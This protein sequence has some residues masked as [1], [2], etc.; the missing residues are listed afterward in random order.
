MA[1][2][3]VIIDDQHDG[4]AVS[5]TTNREEDTYLFDA[6]KREE[7]LKIVIH[8]I[9]KTALIVIFTVLVT[10]FLIRIGHFIIPENLRWLSETQLQT[11]DK[12][13]FSGALGGIMT[14]HI[15]KLFS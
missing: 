4:S 9:T 2:E 10:V 5:Q 8:Y 12:F 6:R 1:D 14:K 11:L 3:L 7:A 15:S 13:F